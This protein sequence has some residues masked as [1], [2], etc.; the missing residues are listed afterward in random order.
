MDEVELGVGAHDDREVAGA[1]RPRRATVARA[2]LRR[3]PRAA[4]T[5]SATTSRGHALA[6]RPDRRARR[7]RA[8][9]RAAA[10]APGRRSSA[11]PSCAADT[12]P[13]TMRGSPSA[14]PRNS[15]SSPRSRSRIAAPVLRER[16]APVGVL[17]RG[18]GRRARRRR[19]RRRSPAWGRRSAPASRRRGRRAAGSPT[20]PGRCPGTRRPARRGSGCAAGRRAAGPVTGSAQ[21]VAQPGEQVVEAEQPAPPLAALD[22]ARARRARSGTRTRGLVV[23]VGPAGTSTA[24]PVADDVARR[25]RGASPA[26]SSAAAHRRRAPLAQVEVVDD[27]G[28]QVVEVLDEHG[29]VVDVAGGA[30]PDRAPAGRTACVVTTVA[31]SKA[32]SATAQPRR[33]TATSPSPAVGEVAAAARRRPARAAAGRAARPAR[34]TS[35]SRT[36]SRSSCVAARPNVTTSS[37]S[38][39]ATPSAT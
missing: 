14:A 4:R 24:L 25:A 21:R 5:I 29:A 31:A 18:A 38:R 12:G 7:R 17:G 37:S 28:D 1:H 20:A 16:R 34:D 36:R 2:Q 9:A 27:L 26:S 3:R 35:R 33:R 8:A 32:A 10:P 23:G 6:G 11:R 22:L 19:G 30:E 13:T 15:A 39:R